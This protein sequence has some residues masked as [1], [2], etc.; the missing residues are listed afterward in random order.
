MMS[1][2]LDSFRIMDTTFEF[3]LENYSETISLI[4]QKSYPVIGYFTNKFPVELVH[5]M[6][7]TPVR[8]I[9]YRVTVVI[10]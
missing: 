5:A 7:L 1:S 10:A 2:H 8:M 6:H 4:K 9:A 3:I